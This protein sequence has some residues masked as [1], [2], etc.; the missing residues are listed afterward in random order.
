MSTV[1]NVQTN[2]NIPTDATNAHAPH[3]SKTAFTANKEF[4]LVSGYSGTGKTSLVTSSIEKMVKQQFGGTFAVGKFDQCLGDTQQ[5]QRPF[6][7]FSMICEALAKEIFTWKTNATTIS[8]QSMFEQFKDQ[9]MMELGTELIDLIQ[10]FP[11]LE[12]IIAFHNNGNHFSPTDDGDGDFSPSYAYNDNKTN[13][14]G[15]VNSE[16]R[17]RFNFAFRVLIRILSSFLSPLV[18]VLDDLQWVDAAS[19]DLLENLLFDQENKNLMIVGIYRSNEVDEKHSLSTTLRHLHS[20][21]YENKLTI[22]EIEIGNLELSGVHE[23]LQA[24]LS[25]GNEQRVVRLAEVCHKKTHGNPFYLIHFISM[26]YDTN[27]LL[28]DFGLMD[29]KW[30]IKSIRQA[31]EATDNVVDILKK[32]MHSL[33]EENQRLLQ[34]AAYL[35]SV[36]DEQSIFVLWRDFQQRR[37]DNKNGSDDG[38]RDNDQPRNDGGDDDDEIRTLLQKSLR[39][40]RKAGFLE[41]AGESMYRWIHDKLQE[42]A[43]NLVPSDE[44]RAFSQRVAEIL[45]SQLNDKEFE[46]VIFV[47][48]NCFNEGIVPSDD[49]TAERLRLARLNLRAA[50]K[51]ASFSAFESAASYCEHGIKLLPADRW[52]NHYQFSL[53]LYSLGAETE[54]LLGNIYKTEKYSKEVIHQ[55]GDGPSRFG[56][57]SSLSSKVRLRDKFRVYNAMIYSSFC[58]NHVKEA[59][60]LCLDVLKQYGTRFPT[61][62]AA[63]TSRVVY[64]VLK[65]KTSLHSRTAEEVNKLPYMND[66]TRVEQMIILDKLASYL[67]MTVSD[68]LPLAIFRSLHFTLQYGLCKLSSPAFATTAVIMAGVIRD[69]RAGLIYANYALLL[70]AKLDPSSIKEVE[71]RTLF[72]V[73]AFVFH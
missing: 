40:C 73:H 4:V 41:G 16:A 57:S 19:L 47:V 2:G 1:D 12:V 45:N 48:T 18:I 39:R 37:N 10:V 23:M 71:S 26:L 46:S 21:S 20:T 36:F 42:A 9:I 70:L 13:N 49:S 64:N 53:D 32:E 67:Y 29:W 8:S 68:L 55:A 66:P 28:Y 31:T 35:G 6:T 25:S 24:L 7:A 44:H 33:S 38:S 30:D 65:I 15:T 14:N 69:F 27:L 62:S 60:D 11:S 63:I 3:P 51:A 22:T 43:M 56:L 72:T 54:G 52:E 59:A 61:T 5:Q 50:K 17:N 34:Y 58:R